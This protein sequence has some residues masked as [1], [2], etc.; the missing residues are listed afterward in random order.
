MD[1]EAERETSRFC[2]PKCRKLA[3]Q[4][5]S[6]S[7]PEN[8]VSVPKDGLA[9]PEKV[10]VPPL[11][12][13]FISA[14]DPGLI[15]AGLEIS[16]EKKR[17]LQSSDLPNV[18]MDDPCRI[19]ETGNETVY[20]DLEKDL[21]LDLKKDL[22]ITA[23]TADG[24]FIRDDIAISQVRAVRML[25]EAKNG[26]PHRTYDGLSNPYSTAKLGAVA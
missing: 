11:S 13:P 4:K 26:W 1:Y 8:G 12:V 2:T 3:F 9:F 20:L 10:S 14:S 25:V 19:V 5:G 18:T 7:V 6:L 16:N 15:L 17:E 23:W 24:I 22:G 21:K